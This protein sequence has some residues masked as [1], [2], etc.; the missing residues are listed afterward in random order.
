MKA[1]SR[2]PTLI[3]DAGNKTLLSSKFIRNSFIREEISERTL[4][5]TKLSITRNI[6][7]PIFS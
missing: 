7:S 5:R 6:I 3:E 2:K 1:F 4:E